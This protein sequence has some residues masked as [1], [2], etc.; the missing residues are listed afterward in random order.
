MKLHDQSDHKLNHVALCFYLT[1][2]SVGIDFAV[3][4]KQSIGFMKLKDVNLQ[5]LSP[6]VLVVSLI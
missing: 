1:V 4:L 6:F 2:A 3:L 5:A